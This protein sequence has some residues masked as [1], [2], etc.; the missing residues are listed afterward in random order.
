MENCS[1]A[2]EVTG[3]RVKPLRW[4]NAP[5]LILGIIVIPA[6]L[7]AFLAHGL[8]SEAVYRIKR[9]LWRRAS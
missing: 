6:V 2:A 9:R 7:L 1:H 8:A 3:K 4:K 5:A